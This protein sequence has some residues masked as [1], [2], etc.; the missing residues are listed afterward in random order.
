[1][2][3][4]VHENTNSL[5]YL[6]SSLSV[7]DDKNSDEG[8]RKLIIF[9]QLFKDG[10]KIVLTEDGSSFLTVH[11]LP[12][13]LK[14]YGIENFKT[15]F[16]LHPADRHKVI[17]NEQEVVAKRWQRSYLKTPCIDAAELVYH[18]Y[19]YSGFDTSK[20]TEDLPGLFVPFHE[21]LKQHI[22][23]KYNQVIA[24]W[25]ENGMD[26]IAKHSDCERCMI[27][28]ASVAIL[29]LY[30]DNTNDVYRML[31]IVPK[32]EARS[33]SVFADVEVVLAHGSVIIMHGDT[34]KEF[35]H[36]IRSDLVNS[37]PRISLSFRQ[38]M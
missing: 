29:S 38:M 31:Q 28:K 10:E 1:M 2:C 14:N 27:P 24:N 34:Q 35:R 5:T 19:M 20:N 6:P 30:G 9:P 11:H 8:K 33:K 25:Y 36:G 3:D 22:S 21:Y 15:M 17:V 37:S 12:E 23:E 7:V 32:R 4:I 13:E 18:S 26:G 16:D